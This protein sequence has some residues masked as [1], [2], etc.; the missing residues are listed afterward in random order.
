L[1]AAAVLLFGIVAIAAL[2][3]PSEAVT[4]GGAQV[5]VTQSPDVIQVDRRCGPG[6]RF[7][8]THRDRAGHLVRGHCVRIRR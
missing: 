5:Q 4:L 3:A 1:R 6:R 7:V 2:P 8:A